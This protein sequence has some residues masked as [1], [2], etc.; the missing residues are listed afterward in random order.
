MK[1]ILLLA[2]KKVVKKNRKSAKTSVIKSILLKSILLITPL[3]AQIKKSRIVANT[4]IVYT[5]IRTHTWPQKQSYASLPVP[6][7][8]HTHTHSLTHSLTLTHTHTHTLTLSAKSKSSRIEWRS[9][10]RWRVLCR[11][12]ACQRTN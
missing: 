2:Q 3:S 8:T 4:Y 7:H 10:A 9:A 5:S 12:K 1:T 11:T 6:T